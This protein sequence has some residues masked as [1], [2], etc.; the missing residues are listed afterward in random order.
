MRDYKGEEINY[1][2]NYNI[3][4]NK[5]LE[6]NNNNAESLKIIELWGGEPL[7]GI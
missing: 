1:P 5:F 3:Y 6:L 7:L 4:I 2:F